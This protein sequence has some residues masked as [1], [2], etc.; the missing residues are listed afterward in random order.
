MHRVR[1]PCEPAWRTSNESIRHNRYVQVY[2]A[3]LG[4][5]RGTCSTFVP[6]GSRCAPETDPSHCHLGIHA[7]LVTL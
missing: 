5:S 2:I 6:K 1:G 7:E 3:R 4:E